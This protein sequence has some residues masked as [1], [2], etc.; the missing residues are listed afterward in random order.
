MDEFKD[1]ANIHHLLKETVERRQ[2]KPAYRW[3][4]APGQ[5]EAISWNG[6]YREVRQAARALI[7]L[8][9]KKGDKVTILSYSCYRW[10]LCDMAIAVI[11]AQTIGIYHSLPGPDVAYIVDHSDS[12]IAFAEDRTQLDKLIQIREQI[13][14]VRKV[15]LFAGDPPADDWVI[16]FEEFMALGESVADEKVDEMS[17]AVSPGDVAG[18]VYTSGTT[19]VPKGSMLTHDNITFTA[20][21][22]AGSV[23]WYP[24]DEVFLF[25]PLAHVFARTCVYTTLLAGCAITFCRGIDHIAED[26]KTARP[27][28]FPSV[29]RIYEKVHAKV[30]GMAEKLADGGEQ[31][32]GKS[33]FPSAF[34]SN[35]ESPPS[36]CCPRFR[37]PWAGGSAGASAGRPP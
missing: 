6:F 36:W 21:S 3:F 1:Y 23:V 25:L 37:R 34:P 32:F 7:A 26:I 4:T 31:E 19:G 28:W 27:H 10:V 5:T 18:I 16:G 11:G 30:T 13:P 33:R 20:Q 15:V 2:D 14:D 8:G 22:V 9:I 35:I 17:A 24:D 29:P 12:V